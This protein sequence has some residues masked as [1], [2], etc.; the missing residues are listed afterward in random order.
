[1]AASINIIKTLKL[2]KDIKTKLSIF[3]VNGIG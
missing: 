3:R 1:M 2:E